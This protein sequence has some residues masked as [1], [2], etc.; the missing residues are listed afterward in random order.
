MP[1]IENPLVTIIIP[2]YNGSNY[3]AQAIDS[4]LAQ[5]YR[6]V[7]ILVINDGS[8]D[9]G[10]TEA[11]AKSYGDKIR[12][13][14]KP[15]GGVSSAL[16]LG[17][18]EMKGSFASWL[19]HDDLYLPNKIEHQM[20]FITNL[21][22]EK[23]LNIEECVVYSPIMVVNSEG[24]FITK[25]HSLFKT[26]QDPTY[27]FSNLIG[28]NLC[29]C[30]SLIPK[31]IFEKIGVFDEKLLTVQD[32]DFWYRILLT[33]HSYYY[34]NTHLVKN[35]RHKGQTSHVMK[36]EWIKEIDSFQSS[37]IKKMQENE[38]LSKI[39]VFLGLAKFL[40]IKGIP[41]TMPLIKKTLKDNTSNL[42]Y[43][44][45]ICPRLLYWKFC[46]HCRNILKIIY[47]KV[48]LGLR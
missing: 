7:E 11:V 19:S 17:I 27:V 46:R 29:G 1:Y 33:G 22:K 18:K 25:S 31:N 42:E 34:D 43:I 44:F 3:L 41:T 20:S 30:A 38:S 8:K 13:I 45:S 28:F 24:K 40:Y 26:I 2:V 39:N 36:D 6:N 14:S 35:R 9:N 32:A 16:N 5:T 48:I 23:N 10:A 47:N 37:L 4:A 15:N 21:S 12:Y